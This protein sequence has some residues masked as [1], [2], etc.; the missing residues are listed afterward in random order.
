MLALAVI[1]VLAFAASPVTAELRGG[2]FQDFAPSLFHLQ[3]VVLPLLRRMGLEASVEME[4]PGYVPRG[5]G[6]V[7]LT[8]S[9]L[10]QPLAPLRPDE[11]SSLQRVWGLSLSSHL[12][13][14]RV[15]ERMA[16][17]AQQVLTQAGHRAEFEMLNDTKSLQP[18]AALAAFADLTGG[19][20]LGADQ[21]GALRRSAEAIGKHVAKQLLE[22][23]R[24]GATVD[25]YAA[26]Q[27]LPFAA[28]ADGETR[29]R[30]PSETEHVQ[31]NAWLAHEFVGAEVT[32]KDHELSIQGVGFFLQRS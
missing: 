3:H 21:A 20:R 11:P 16:S 13:Q 23:L 4:R 8:V 32:V 27:V 2:L 9:P 10:Q 22:D 17:S 7:H 1:P 29:Y 14:R 24:T 5:G 15:S 31:T 6:I 25:R 30:L 26:D 18:G 28:L 12:D 19:M